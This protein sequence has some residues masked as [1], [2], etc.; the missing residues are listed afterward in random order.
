M[1]YKIF[2]F[3]TLSTLVFFSCGNKT[4]DEK[5]PVVTQS[6]ILPPVPEQF[7]VD[8]YEKI[9]HIDYYFRNTNFSVSQDSPEAVKSFISLLS[10]GLAKGVSDSCAS[11]LRMTFLSQGNILFETEMYMTD[12][13]MYVEYYIDNKKTYH[14]S[15][16]E[17]GYNFLLN[18]IES[19]KRGGK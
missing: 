12:N 16:S 3:F 9:D 15:H 10:P 18:I 14:S 1:K 8:M 2:V 17:Q 13:C 7:I 19:A 4:T 11:P 5:Q 6:K